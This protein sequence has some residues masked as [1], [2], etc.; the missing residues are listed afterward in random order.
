MRKSVWHNFSNQD[1]NINL[2]TSDKNNKIFK[3]RK[4]Y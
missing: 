4:I 1:I 3:K 2:A